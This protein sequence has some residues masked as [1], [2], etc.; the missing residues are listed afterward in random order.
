MKAAQKCCLCVSVCFVL[1]RV[2]LLV[3]FC[4]LCYA[5]LR[6]F[7]VSVCLCFLVQSSV[8]P[9]VHGRDRPSHHGR[10]FMQICSFKRRGG[11]QVAASLW[12]RFFGSGSH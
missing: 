1:C 2:V 11:K 12:W 6:C 8:A 10:N 7:C 3:C 4:V 9:E 5:G